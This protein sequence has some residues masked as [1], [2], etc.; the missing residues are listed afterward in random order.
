MMEGA[1]IEVEDAVV[2]RLHDAG[3][4]TH[5]VQ[6]D[7]TVRVPIVDSYFRVL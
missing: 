3:R 7:E 1:D 2:A 5:E 6:A 4:T